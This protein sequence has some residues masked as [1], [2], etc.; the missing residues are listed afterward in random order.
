MSTAQKV[1]GAVII[2]L[3]I[4]VFVACVGVITG[5][6]VLRS[7]ILAE[8]RQITGQVSELITNVDGNV[9]QI[10]TR[11]NTAL[12]RN[13]AIRVRA[14]EFAARDLS[15]TTVNSIYATLVAMIG[16]ELSPTIE[17]VSD[18]VANVTERVNSLNQSI[19]LAN[20]VPGV[21]LPLLQLG[22][23]A[24]VTESIATARAE[25]ITLRNRVNARRIEARQEFAA[26]VIRLTQTV[27]AAIQPNVQRVG[28]LR[29]RLD[30]LRQNVEAVPQLLDSRWLMPASLAV[31]FVMFWLALG[32]VALAWAGWLLIRG[33]LREV[34]TPSRLL[35]PAPPAVLTPSTDL[36]A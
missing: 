24:I 19:R 3:S 25:V 22:E 33:R 4:I 35:P 20:R 7:A 28:G 9:A 36:P 26:D 32:Q 17:R 34:V 18:A 27:D 16:E 5:A 31:T 1:G 8:A 23:I 10:E 15:E 2:A 21:N 14:Q 30:G 13:E 12:Q 29:S 6:W 11:L